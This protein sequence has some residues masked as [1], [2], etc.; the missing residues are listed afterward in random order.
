MG[1]RRVSQNT[2]ARN[3][4][5]LAQNMGV[6][7]RLHVRDPIDPA[8]H[9]RQLRRVA[10]PP[11]ARQRDQR[12]RLVETER[13]VRRRRAES[14]LELAP[15]V[16]RVIRQPRT[17][18]RCQLRRPQRV[19]AVLHTLLNRLPRWEVLRRPQRVRAELHTAPIAARR[20]VPQMLVDRPLKLGPGQRNTVSVAELLTPAA[21]RPSPVWWLT[22][23]GPRPSASAGAFRS[24]A[25]T[26]QR[27]F[28]PACSH[29]VTRATA[30]PTG[31]DRTRGTRN[32]RVG[33]SRHRRVGRQQLQLHCRHRRGDA[34]DAR[35]APFASHARRRRSAAPAR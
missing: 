31:T 13:A 3:P 34:C 26:T 14:R 18:R 33:R 7:S 29:C 25:C 35:K 5:S 6:G 1:S 32:R 22:S 30:S 12:L 4:P 23:V 28:G 11:K 2:A 16:L 8:A 20:R 21:R 19:R 10:P 24:N 17:V 15:T 9:P 27:K